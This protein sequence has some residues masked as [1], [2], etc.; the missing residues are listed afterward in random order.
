MRVTILIFLL[1]NT[2][3]ITAQ[4]ISFVDE[5]NNSIENVYLEFNLDG[6][7]KKYSSDKDGLITINLN[8]PK[9]T[10]FKISHIFC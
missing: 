2:L 9:E 4:T 10:I 6:V 1:F 5:K 8:Y 7:N 3:L